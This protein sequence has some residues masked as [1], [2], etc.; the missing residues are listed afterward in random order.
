VEP[1]EFTSNGGGGDTLLRRVKRRKVTFYGVVNIANPKTVSK[2]VGEGSEIKRWLLA[3]FTG[4]L[5]HGIL[6]TW[7][8]FLD[9]SH[10][11]EPG[12]LLSAWI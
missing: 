5:T 3:M 2:Y 4:M 12:F 11:N 10:I 8:P 9:E 6:Y 1:F 7:Y